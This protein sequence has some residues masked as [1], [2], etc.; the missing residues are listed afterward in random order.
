MMGSPDG[1]KVKTECTF[2]QEVGSHVEPAVRTSST[3]K[4]PPGFSPPTCI[5][6]IIVLPSFEVDAIDPARF[7]FGP[8]PN[9]MF[10]A[11]ESLLPVAP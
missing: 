2:S 9:G 11:L 6:A 10:H 1:T 4:Y 8:V 7:S 3:S 5:P